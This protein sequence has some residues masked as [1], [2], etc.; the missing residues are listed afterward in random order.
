[1]KVTTPTLIIDAEEGSLIVL[2]RLPEIVLTAKAS[3][4][5]PLLCLAA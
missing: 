5:T 1:M 3:L 2:S 4:M